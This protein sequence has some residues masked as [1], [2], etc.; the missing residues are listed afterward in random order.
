MKNKKED[1]DE[2]I[3]KALHEEEAEFYHQLD[4]QSLPEMLL[5]LYQGKLAWV[6]VMSTIYTVVFLALSIYCL[7]QFLRAD[8][9]VALIKWGSGMFFCIIAQMMSKLFQWM[10]MDKNAILREIK[11]LE[12]QITLL[13]S[14][15][16]KS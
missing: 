16:P 1:I 3:L 6:V 13:S 8:D 14:K 5:G 4:E 11:R 12:L 2:L 9:V 10:Q 15:L 7:V